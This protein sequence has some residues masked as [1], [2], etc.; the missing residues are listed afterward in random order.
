[1]ANFTSQTNRNTAITNIPRLTFQLPQTT[2][3]PTPSTITPI[4]FCQIGCQLEFEFKNI[5]NAQL[6]NDGTYFTITPDENSNNYINWN[7][8]GVSGQNLT[9]FD[10]K[11][12]NFIAPAKDVVG[13]I[14]Y[15]KSIQFFF[16]FVNSTYPNIMIVITIIGKS[17]NVGTAKTDGYVLLNSLAAQIPLRNETKTVS[18]LSNVNLGFLLPNNKSFFSTLIN[19][20]SVQY[21]S[22]TRVI[23]IPDIFLNNMISRV[24]GSQQAYDSKVNRNLQQIPTNPL[25]TII[26]YTENIKPISS[27]EAYVCNSNCDLVVGN[28]SLLQPTFGTSNTIRSQTGSVKPLYNGNNPTIGI[29]DEE[30]E[31]EYI[32][33]G[34][35]TNVN[36]KSNTDTS[37]KSSNTNQIILPII[38]SA[39]IIAGSALT[40]WML[41]KATNLSGFKALFTSELWQVK[42]IGLII[43]A[44]IGFL[45]III[46]ISIF[47]D[48][49]VKQN[50]LEYKEESE[51]TE[52]YKKI[53]NDKP[54]IYFIIGFTI[55]SLSILILSFIFFRNRRVDNSASASNYFNRPQQKNL[56]IPINPEYPQLSGISQFSKLSSKVLNDYRQSPADFFKPGSQG[57]KDILDLSRQYQN[58]NPL[59]KDTLAKYK[60]SISPFLASNSDFMRNIKSSQFPSQPTLNSFIDNLE[61]ASQIS[62]SPPK[63]TQKLID[64]FKERQLSKPNNKDLENLISQLQVGKDIPLDVYKY[65]KQM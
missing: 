11:E 21:I 38:F 33:P 34:T 47:T 54:Y 63:V 60:Q 64:I 10:L 18:N 17:N 25:G 49:L 62:Q 48:K 51:K 31:E 20:N 13:S 3:R 28:A 57:A 29:Q 26:F 7:G 1:M 19:N 35:K 32:Y 45:S 22:M 4:Y 9:R 44:L 58:L 41:K 24:I 42:N 16:T 46:F 56:E 5:S 36:I 27:D 14:T 8:S 50:N 43:I 6:K 12:I 2:T 55:W 59:A 40:I 15:N 30:C 52:D 61:Y 23:D 37:S 65:V 39:V 53:E